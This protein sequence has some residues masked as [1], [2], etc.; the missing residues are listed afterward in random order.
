MK[1]KE[2]SFKAYISPSE[3]EMGQGKKHTTG[4]IRSNS[5]AGICPLYLK[6][7]APIFCK[8]IRINSV[9]CR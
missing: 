4:K 1:D 7:L 9:S 8:F 3:V 6:T 2:S 5:N